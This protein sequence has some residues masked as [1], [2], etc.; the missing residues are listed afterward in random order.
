MNTSTET[1]TV[2]VEREFAASPEK[3]WRALTQPHLIEEWLMKNDFRPDVGHNFQFRMEPQHGWNGIID[4]RVVEIDPNRALTYTWGSMG[5]ETVVTF[6]LTRSGTGTHL[7]V[8]QSGFAADQAQAFAG[9]TYGWKNFLGKL[10]QLLA[11]S[12]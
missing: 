8:E 4:C 1:R 2:T 12:E 9:A 10:D 5:T 11:R 7:R 6:T 3:L